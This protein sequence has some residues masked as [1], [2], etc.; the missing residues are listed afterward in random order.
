[1]KRAALVTNNPGA[2]ER[3]YGQGRRESLAGR[4]RL[5]PGIVTQADFDSR[6]H[7]LADL[8]VIFSTW[9]LWRFTPEQ[10]AA[11]PRLEA[12][13]YAAGSV[14][15][16]AEPLLDRDIIVVS[17]WGANAVPVVEEFDRWVCGEPLRC[18]V[19]AH[20]LAWMV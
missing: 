4:V 13:F 12:V 3:V 16:F 11:M 6:L 17:G 15:G 7:A 20:M 19:T 14:K 5:H 18:R 10:I 8:E 9:G 2:V 1:M